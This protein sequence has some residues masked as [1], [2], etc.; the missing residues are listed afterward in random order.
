MAQFGIPDAANE[1][2]RLLPAPYLPTYIAR[3]P[4]RSKSNLEYTTPIYTSIYANNW[5]KASDNYAAKHRSFYDS[6][7]IN[8]DY[9]SIQTTPKEYDTYKQ[10]LFQQ[11]EPDFIEALNRVRPFT[12]P[13]HTT[14]TS[15]QWSRFL[16]EY[17]DRF[18]ID[19]PLS[20]DD[21]ILYVPP[22]P[23]RYPYQPYRE[24]SNLYAGLPNKIHPATNPFR[25]MESRQNYTVAHPIW[26]PYGTPS[27]R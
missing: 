16:D 19:Y 6:P 5:P 20:N 2:G 14:R 25:Q 24:E 18:K 11:D 12:V 9:D 17:P 1:L 13:N 22:R 23:G 15:L 21:S 8:I 27:R 10:Y 7:F 4:I 3:R 26:K